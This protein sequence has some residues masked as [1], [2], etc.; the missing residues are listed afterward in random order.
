VQ[1]ILKR[2]AKVTVI[3]G[4]THQLLTNKI[5]NIHFHG[6]LSTAWPWPYAPQ[7]TP[8][9]TV[10]MNRSDP[11]NS[12]DGCGNGRIN[13]SADGLVDKIYG[14]WNRKPIL[15]SAAYLKSE[16]KEDRPPSPNLPAY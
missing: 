1:A 14:L 6:L 12:L 9:L 8:E 2:F 4:H 7:G 10:Q 15:V 11:F 5:G 13:V 16:G 3:H